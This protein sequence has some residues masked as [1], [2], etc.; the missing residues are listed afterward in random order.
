MTST[1]ATWPESHAVE[2][3]TPTIAT[4]PVEAADA[5]W[6]ACIDAI[7]SFWKSAAP[8]SATAPDRR[9]AQAAL[10]QLQRLRRSAPHLIPIFVIPESSGRGLVVEHHVAKDVT[11]EFTYF[12][13]GGAE[14]TIYR[15][16]LVTSMDVIST[17]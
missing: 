2:I 7:L 1:I 6:E 11:L 4:D 10:R 13:E 15:D 5:K 9:A 16:G 17:S 14:L 12:N 8:R 3:S